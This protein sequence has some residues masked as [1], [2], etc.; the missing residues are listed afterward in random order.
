MKEKA[1][2]P[3]PGQS[4]WE[5]LHRFVSLRNFHALAKARCKPSRV[6]LALGPGCI[7]I[8]LNHGKDSCSARQFRRLRLYQSTRKETLARSGSSATR[9]LRGLASLG[10]L[11]LDNVTRVEDVATL[12]V[13]W[14]VGLQFM[15]AIPSSRSLL[16]DQLCKGDIHQPSYGMKS[17]GEAWRVSRY[18]YRRSGMDGECDGGMRY[19]ERYASRYDGALIQSP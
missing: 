12:R 1:L 18:Y 8:L 5:R 2:C 3:S 7:L 6:R 10:S 13:R 15:P 14:Y 4:V 19:N 16:E 9:P 17:W 11:L